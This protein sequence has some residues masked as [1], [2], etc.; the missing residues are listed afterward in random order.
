MPVFGREFLDGARCRER[1]AKGFAMSDKKYQAEGRKNKK[2]RP[3]PN[4]AFECV[5]FSAKG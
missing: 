3:I 1:V 4:A 5:F 2:R